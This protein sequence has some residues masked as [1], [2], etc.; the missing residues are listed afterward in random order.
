MVF[1]WNMFHSPRMPPS[2]VL[3]LNFI[4]GEISWR[5]IAVMLVWVA[6]PREKLTLRESGDIWR[7]WEGPKDHVCKMDLNREISSVEPNCATDMVMLLL[8][9][10]SSNL[11]SLLHW[12]KIQMRDSAVKLTLIRCWCCPS[13]P[14]EGQGWDLVLLLW[15]SV[16]RVW[17]HVQRDMDLS[18]QEEVRLATRLS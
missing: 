10:H 18:N 16:G 8:W 1:G 14:E 6:G 5:Q 13:G 4:L 11:L 12:L 17:D 7:A 15:E 3:G 9:E 2:P